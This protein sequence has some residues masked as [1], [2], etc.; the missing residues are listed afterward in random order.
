MLIFNS[1][2]LGLQLG[3]RFWLEL[4]LGFMIRIRVKVYIM[5]NIMIRFGVFIKVGVR[6][7]VS[8]REGKRFTLVIK[9]RHG[10]YI[11][12]NIMDEVWI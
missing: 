9:D 5:F 11:M 1:I 3:F 2:V 4:R 6:I 10:I 8:F 7:K 12:I